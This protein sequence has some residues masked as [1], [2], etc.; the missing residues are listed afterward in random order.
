MDAECIKNWH[1][2]HCRAIKSRLK[3]FRKPLSDSEIFRELC[4]CILT[5]NASAMMGLNTIKAA[6][7][8]IFTA[9]ADR[10]AEIFKGKHRFYRKRAEYIVVTREY[11]KQEFGFKLKKLLDS[12]DTPAARRRFFAENPGIKGIGYKEASHFLRNIGYSGYAILDKHILNCLRE[13]AVIT[14]EDKKYIEIEQK[15]KLFARALKINIDEL[16]FVLWSYKTGKIL[17]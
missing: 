8:S 4:F 10:L 11:L 3:E 12:F 13:A 5:A 6:G 14:A 9:T 17:K 1:K 15:M 2:L 7:D 16:D